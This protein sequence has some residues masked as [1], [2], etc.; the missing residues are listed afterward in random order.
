[1]L[2][3]RSICLLAVVALA[4]V[5]GLAHYPAVAEAH[6]CSLAGKGRSLGPTYTLSLSVRHTTCRTG[7]RVVTAFDR[8]R[9]HHGK[10][11]HCRHRVLHYR[12][13]EHRFDR[14]STQYDSRVSCRRGA[15]RV[16]FTYEQFT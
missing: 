16:K 6:G 11:G 5:V 9:K 4:A 3:R 7:Y 2:V 10:A 13:R 14:I 1:M 12:C 15:R 8:C